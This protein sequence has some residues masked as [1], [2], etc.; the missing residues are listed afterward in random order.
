LGPSALRAYG[1]EVIVNVNESNG[2]AGWQGLDRAEAKLME[3]FRGMVDHHGFSE[4]RVEARIMKDAR[5]E[6]IL[7]FGKQY[8]FV[9]TK[10]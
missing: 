9:L 2:P 7:S 1:K 5:K 8:R 6:V 10:Q 4:L 3:L